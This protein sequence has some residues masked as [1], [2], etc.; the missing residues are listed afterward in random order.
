MY[1]RFAPIEDCVQASS[2][3]DTQEASSTKETQIDHS[4]VNFS[5]F[6]RRYAVAGQIQLRRSQEFAA[7]TLWASAATSVLSRAILRRSL[8]SAHKWGKNLGLLEREE[9]K[10]NGDKAT[11]GNC[12]A[13]EAFA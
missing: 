10:R 1:R 13:D 3:E 5:S 2:S 7:R 9:R 8:R 11:W 12:T 4:T 6:S